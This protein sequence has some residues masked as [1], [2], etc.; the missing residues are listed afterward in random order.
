MQASPVSSNSSS[1]NSLLDRMHE[2]GSELDTTPKSNGEILLEKLQEAG[3]TINSQEDLDRLNNTLDRQFGIESTSSGALQEKTSAFSFRT[4]T[5]TFDLPTSNQAD[6][7]GKTYN[8]SFQD[9]SYSPNQSKSIS[10]GMSENISSMMQE[11]T[12]Q[13]QSEE[14]SRAIHKSFTAAKNDPSSSIESLYASRINQGI[15]NQAYT[16]QIH[17][18]F[19]VSKNSNI[20]SEILHADQIKAGNINAQNRAQELYSQR[21]SDS[22]TTSKNLSSSNFDDL[23]SNRIKTGQINQ[24]ATIAYNKNKNTP[25]AQFDNLYS[26]RIAQGQKNQAFASQIHQGFEASKNLS[27]SNFDNL[28]AGRIAQ[29]QVNQANVQRIHESFENSKN[30]S[31]SNFDNLYADRIAQ[32]QQNQKRAQQIHEGFENS[33]N[34]SYANFDNIYAERIAQGQ[35]NQEARRLQEEQ[36]RQQ[37]YDRQQKYVNNPLLLNQTL[38]N[39]IDSGADAQPNL[40][41]V[42]IFAGHEGTEFS[43]LEA[44]D[45]QKNLTFR[46][47]NF[48]AP[49]KQ[50]Q[51]QDLSYQTAVYK[52]IMP[53]S[54]LTRQ[55]DFNIRLDYNY[56]IYWYLHRIFAGDSFGN[57]DLNLLDKNSQ[58]YV[59]TIQVKALSPKQVKLGSIPTAAEEEAYRTAYITS[60]AQFDISYSWTFFDCYLIQIPQVAFGYDQ[61]GS[62][63]PTFSFIFG[64]MTEGIGE[65]GLVSTPL[66]DEAFS[67]LNR[68]EKLSL[69]E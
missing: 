61:S 15:Q 64:M 66:R 20:S 60:P 48:N 65:T 58:D 59:C 29:G 2:L 69:D 25:Q 62:V 4:P 34:A 50:L 51:S 17:K 55:L 32:G 16:Q 10:L 31:S 37:E 38:A 43:G 11:S 47:N 56:K 24:Q 41:E 5:P 68:D 7:F 22:F 35:R 27:S 9:I 30:L 12:K 36:A 45:I 26:D 52:K 33:K 28:Y 6:P 49:A 8:S 13:W 21:I 42:T 1:Y 3:A 14:S 40:F 19:E 67:L 57:F 63:T 39:L 54:A 23:Y 46:I 44:L 53:G 18:G